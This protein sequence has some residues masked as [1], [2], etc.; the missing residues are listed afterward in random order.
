MT[1]ERESEEDQGEVWSEGELGEQQPHASP[2]N[3]LPINAGSSQTPVLFDSSPENP[4]QN[5][6]DSND[7][8]LGHGHIGSDDNDDVVIVSDVE[9]DGQRE[10]AHQN[11]RTNRENR[12]AGSQRTP[13][14]TEGEK[15]GNSGEEMGMAKRAG[16]YVDEDVDSV[17]RDTERIEAE[18][19][20]QTVSA[21]H[22][23]RI[24]DTS[25]HYP[26]SFEPKGTEAPRTNVF[27][28]SENHAAKRGQ[29]SSNQGLEKDNPFGLFSDEGSREP[30]GNTATRVKQLVWNPRT[31]PPSSKAPEPNPLPREAIPGE[32]TAE[33][34][35]FQKS[36][37]A[38]QLSL[39][40]KQAARESRREERIRLE[41][42]NEDRRLGA[43]P[44]T[45][46]RGG[47][48]SRFDGRERFNGK[49]WERTS[50]DEQD[51]RNV[52]FPLLD[53]E[54]G[55][56]SYP[57]T[58]TP[59]LRVPSIAA[60]EEDSPIQPWRMPPSELKMRQ[61]GMVVRR[62]ANEVDRRL[63]QKV[64]EVGQRATRASRKY[65]IEA[66]LRSHGRMEVARKTIAFYEEKRL[67]REE[68]HQAQEE[69]SKEIALRALNSMQIVVDTNQRNYEKYEGSLD[70]VKDTGKRVLDELLKEIMRV[71]SQ[72]IERV[73][74][75]QGEVAEAMKESSNMTEQAQHRVKDIR[76]TFEQASTQIVAH[77][78]GIQKSHVSTLEHLNN[79]VET[80]VDTLR[81]PSSPTPQ[82][83]PLQNTGQNPFPSRSEDSLVQSIPPVPQKSTNGER[84]KLRRERRLAEDE[85]MARRLQDEEQR[86][87]ESE[88]ETGPEPS[89]RPDRN[90]RRRMPVENRGDGDEPTPG[91]RE[92]VLTRN[93]SALGPPLEKFIEVFD[94]Q[95][96]TDFE[97]W[98]GI[99]NRTVKGYAR[100]SPVEKQNLLRVFLKGSALDTVNQ[101]EKGLGRDSTL[102]E[103]LKQLRKM[104]NASSIASL[105]DVKRCRRQP[106]E[107]IRRYSIRLRKVVDRCGD[108]LF[109]NETSRANAVLAQF[110]QG[111]EDTHLTVDLCASKTVDDAIEAYNRI[112]DLRTQQSAARARSEESGQHR[113]HSPLPRRHES[114]YNDRSRRP[115]PTFNREQRLVGAIKGTRQEKE[116]E[117]EQRD[118]SQ[119]SYVSGQS[120]RR[121]NSNPP[122]GDRY[123]QSYNPD[124]YCEYHRSIGHRTAECRGLLK[125]QA[126]YDALS[127]EQSLPPPPF[128]Q[129]PAMAYR[130]P[131]QN[132]TPYGHNRP[133]NPAIPPPNPSTPPLNP[134]IQPFNPAIPPSGSVVPLFPPGNPPFYPQNQPNPPGNFQGTGFRGRGQE[135]YAPPRRLLWSRT[136]RQSPFPWNHPSPLSTSSQRLFPE[137]RLRK[138]R[139][140]PRR[141]RGRGGYGY[142]NGDR[143]RP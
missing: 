134:A 102:E 83:L 55:P 78:D 53:D 46:A 81:T 47:K 88:K 44:K 2:K 121:P 139:R 33:Y 129:Y 9:E 113:P 38:I 43:R 8:K 28:G 138:G 69:H 5:R 137:F 36:A 108:N 16:V 141:H 56:I 76:H 50:E 65:G 30:K 25:R 39:A 22:S 117:R 77:Q 118:S 4:R 124:H 133:F 49:D 93:G 21:A 131:G 66:D 92:Q 109:N 91:N 135:P 35:S 86:A 13:T 32:N 97:D 95:G 52:P 26:L 67:E 136:T 110:K 59:K 57:P 132:G 14:G 51:P 64:E 27:S 82:A 48:V 12:P 6:E 24:D 75:V 114:P 72:G 70:C 111:I 99:F 128:P 61:L 63:Q 84:E 1:R 73:E 100:V 101:M 130:G 123:G 142:G 19:K 96:M 45:Y 98:Y 10:F 120:P 54:H 104:F 85:E 90:E 11:Q 42:Q 41:N 20:N 68:A 17:I 71:N 116:T 103:D 15:S 23:H 58:A 107:D 80:L 94:G 18:A 29:K 126:Y 140:N 143:P 37:N 89:A 122:V 40:E 62:Q 115:T 119:V 87:T 7:W 74:R 3:P 112:D 34:A 106:G 79:A 125:K 31:R 127:G 60:P 105:E